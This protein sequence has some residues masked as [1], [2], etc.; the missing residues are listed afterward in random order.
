MADSATANRESGNGQVR[1]LEDL[2]SSIEGLNVIV[3]EDILRHRSYAQLFASRA[4]AAPPENAAHRRD[5][6]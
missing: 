2:D 3:V 1:L 6:G 5:A 4:A